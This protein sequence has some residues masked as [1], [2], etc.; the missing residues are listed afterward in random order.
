MKNN[1]IHYHRLAN[2]QNNANDDT[3]DEVYLITSYFRAF[4]SNCI[5]NYTTF[6]LK[7]IFLK[8]N[9]N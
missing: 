4:Y 6:V 2:E 9:E 1:V 5:S 7:H 3:T 8:K